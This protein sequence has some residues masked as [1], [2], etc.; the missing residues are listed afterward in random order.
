MRFWPAVRTLTTPE[1]G[2]AAA[3]FGEALELDPIRILAAPWPVRRAF[4]AGRWFGRDWI[5]WP[6]A[7]LPADFLAASL[8]RQ[9]VLIHELVHVWQ[10][11]QGVNLLAAKLRAGDRAETYVYPIEA[12]QWPA[13]NIEQQAMAVEHAFR[14]SRGGRAPASAGFYRTV[15]PFSHCE[16]FRDLEVRRA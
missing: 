8:G 16:A 2:L 6:R 15:L 14:L 4:V 5:A 11:Q 3:V 13:L 10:A 7:A 9:A 12:C 1:R